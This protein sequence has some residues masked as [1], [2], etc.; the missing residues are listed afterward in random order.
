MDPTSNP[1]NQ[2]APPVIYNPRPSPSRQALAVLLNLC[3]LLFLVDGG[4]C[5][6]DDSLSL[7]FNVQ[8]LNGIRGIVVTFSFLSALIVYGLVG[9]TSVIPKRVFLPVALFNPVTALLGIPLLIYFYRHLLLLSWLASLLQVVIGLGLLWYL[10]R[11][12]RFHWPPF[13]AG[14]LKTGRFSLL[15]LAVFL[16]ANLLILLPALVVYLVFCASFAVDHFSEGF[17]ALRPAGFTVQV[18]KYARN[19]GKAIWLV[20]MSHIGEPEFYRGLSQGFPQN[21]TILM[22]GVT[23]NENL[24]TNRITYKRVASSLGLAAQEKQFKPNPSQV[25]MADIDVDQFTPGTIGFLNLVMLIHSHGFTVENLLRILQYPQPPGFEQQ[26]FEDLLTKRNRH[27]LQ[28]IQEHL[29][30]ANTLIVPWGAAHMPE[31]SRGIQKSGFQ[32]AGNQ[33]YVAIRFG[34]KHDKVEASP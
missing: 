22:E 6:L 31:I 14:M 23:D 15:R 8:F 28:E 19:D 17:V 9:C 33:E 21:S 27:L 7:L 10:Q 32:L 12:P 11:G 29:S 4:V 3:L 30:E 20:P 34:K 24:L 25:V 26:L 16:A 13:P 18:K 5:L 2:G 1:P